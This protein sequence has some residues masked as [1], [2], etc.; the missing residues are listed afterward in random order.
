MKRPMRTCQLGY[1][2]QEMKSI[3]AVYDVVCA[4]RAGMYILPQNYYIH[5]GTTA[6]RFTPVHP[7]DV[8]LNS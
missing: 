2:Y 6:K 8:I 3:I 4:Y 5:P 1:E 7:M